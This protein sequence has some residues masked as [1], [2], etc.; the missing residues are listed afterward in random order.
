MKTVAT[1]C[2][3]L[4]ATLLL[5]VVL[6]CC[7]ALLAAVTDLLAGKRHLSPQA[8]LSLANRTLAAC[9]SEHV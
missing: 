1:N 7:L 5:A 2:G 8:A 9:K 6:T 4:L 3:H